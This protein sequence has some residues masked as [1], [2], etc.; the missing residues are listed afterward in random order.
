VAAGRFSRFGLPAEYGKTR[1]K[2]NP[3]DFV[4]NNPA[5]LGFSGG[6]MSAAADLLA[7]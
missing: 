1:L 2:Q 4:Y 6:G 7:I 3:V 5:S